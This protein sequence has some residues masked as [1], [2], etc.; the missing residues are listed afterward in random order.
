MKYYGFVSPGVKIITTDFE[1]IR[2]LI[3]IVQYPKFKKFRTKAEA[4]K[5]VME[6]TMEFQTKSLIKYGECFEKMYITAE[7]FIRENNVYYNLYTNA[8]GNVDLAETEFDKFM[9]KEKRNG[10][11]M[12]KMIDMNLNENLISSHVMVITNLLKIVG[13]LVDIELIIPNHSIYYLLK[14]YTGSY[15]PYVK[16]REYID[17]RKGRLCVTMLNWGGVYEKEYKHT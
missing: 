13:S 8:L 7:Y 14:S 2:G 17:S 5:F 15:R 4:I 6:N 1:E 12:L 16:L 3:N 11:V 10:I 9:L